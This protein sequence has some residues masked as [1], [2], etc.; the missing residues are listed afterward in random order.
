MVKKYLK[1]ESKINHINT[2]TLNLNT[3]DFLTIFNHFKGTSVLTINPNTKDFK[4]Q[5][6]RWNPKKEISRNNL[7][8]V[9]N[10]EWIKHLK[11]KNEEE[12]VLTYGVEKCN[13]IEKLL[14]LI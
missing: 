8:L 9:T 11:L 5:F 14:A 3:N 1:H 13:E 6:V 4:T 10:P 2:N 7:I 12:L